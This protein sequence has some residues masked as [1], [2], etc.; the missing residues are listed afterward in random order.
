MI[1]DEDDAGESIDSEAPASGTGG[2]P[3]GPGGMGGV[4]GGMSNREHRPNGG[5]SPMQD[6]PADD[7]SDRG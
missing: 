4:R 2:D 5:V 6:G 7:D 1:E 3:G